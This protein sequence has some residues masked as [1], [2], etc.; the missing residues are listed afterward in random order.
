MN[1]AAPPLRVGIACFSTFGGSGV[2]ASEIGLTL[3]ARGHTVH[4]FSDD[5]PGRLG[6]GSAN[7]YFHRVEIRSFPQLKDSPYALGLTSKIVEVARREGLDLL[8]AHYAIPH[9][10]SAYLARQVLGSTAPAIVT[11]L[12]GT[13]ITLVGND[14]SFL[15]LTRF[16]IMRS[17]AV[18][19]PSAWLA[20]ATHRLLDIP[21]GLTIEV[22]PNF[23]DTA[24]FAPSPPNDARTGPRGRPT[25]LVHVSNFRALKRVDDVVAIFVEARRRLL[26]TPLSLWMVGDGPDR[27]RIRQRVDALDL[28]AH[29]QFLG[30]RIDLP[31][32]LR[33]A[34]VFLLPSES[35]SFGLA[36]L[37]A[38]SC[39][40]PVVA[41]HVGGIP[42]VVI[43]GETGLLAPVGDVATMATHVVKLLTDSALHARFASAARER[44]VTFFPLE[45]TVARYESLY[46]RLLAKR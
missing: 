9:A 43:D 1:T 32:V 16:S 25:V 31:D 20:E 11:T 14:P 6:E 41:S 21:R 36:A 23:V 15:P 4:V 42:E 37:E 30:E 8:H 18:T 17:D 29:V 27:E 24:R 46:R 33:H 34:D 10:I 35:E 44:A 39:G 22:I 45:P 5:R 7:V 19:A 26:E 38:M 40:V 13:D 28:T 3:A 12:H 2:V